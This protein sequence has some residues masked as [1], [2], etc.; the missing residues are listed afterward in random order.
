MDDYAKLKKTASKTAT[1]NT[2]AWKQNEADIKESL[3]KAEKV[4]EYLKKSLTTHTDN[5]KMAYAEFGGWTKLADEIIEKQTAHAAA[6]KAKDKAKMKDIEK[7]LKKLEKSASAYETNISKG[8]ETAN[9]HLAEVR[10]CM[11][12]V[13]AVVC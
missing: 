7:E 1:E 6:K 8:V 4:V 12:S 2:D 10:K 9:T 13:D 11:T 5:S 3:K